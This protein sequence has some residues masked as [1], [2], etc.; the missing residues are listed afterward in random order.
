[1]SLLLE[2][3]AFDIGSCQ[4]IERAGGGRI[5]LCAN[6]AEGGTTV[7][8]GMIKAA[9]EA[10]NIPVFPIIRPRGGDFLYSNAEFDIMVQDVK[11]CKEIGMD[12]VVF[13]FLDAAGNVD[14]EKTSR[15]AAIAYPMEVTFHRAFDHSREPMEALEDIIACGCNRILSSGTADVASNGLALLKKMV[16]AAADRIIILPGSGIRANNIAAIAR[17]TGLQEFHT[18]ARKQLIPAGSFNNKNIP[19]ASGRWTVDEAEVKAAVSIL[20][21]IS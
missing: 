15:L 10:V 16:A 11:H 13:G 7:S 14:K 4:L 3:I 1:M 17:E 6:P 2:V 12:G 5:E 19:A 20:R 8:Y 18:S 9:R 21:T